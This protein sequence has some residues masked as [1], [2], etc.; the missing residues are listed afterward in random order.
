MM[1]NR[2]EDP[3]VFDARCQFNSSKIRAAPMLYRPEEK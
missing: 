2:Y 3:T 1:M